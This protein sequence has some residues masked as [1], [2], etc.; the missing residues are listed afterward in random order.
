MATIDQ[1]PLK[2]FVRFDGTGRIVPSSLI[3]RRKKPKVGKWVEIPAYECCN[4]TTQAPAFRLVFDSIESADALVGDSANV[5]DWNTFFDLPTNGIPFTSVVIVENEVRLYGGAYI[6]IVSSLLSNNDSIVSISDDA[7]SIVTIEDDAFDSHTSL[8]SVSFPAVTSIGSYSFGFNESNSVFVSINF[9][10]LETIGSDAFYYC[11]ALTSFNFPLAKYIG[12]WAFEGCSSMTSLYT[13]ILIE[14]G[15]TT[16]D[17][18]VFDSITGNNITLT[19]PAALMTCN[20]G[21]PDGDIVYLQANNTVTIVT[22]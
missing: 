16:G 18:D 9:P 8:V 21:N 11:D 4:P 10:K 7:Q 3:L 17:D 14:L 2:A 5:S 19:V 15:P 12:D 20:S 22:T 13:P 1:R 6:T